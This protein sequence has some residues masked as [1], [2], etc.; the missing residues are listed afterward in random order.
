MAATGTPDR[1]AIGRDRTSGETATGRGTG[2]LTYPGL[3]ARARAGAAVLRDRQARALV[4]IGVNGSAFAEALF[5]SA[6][7]GIP[8]VPLNYRLSREQLAFLL[9]RQERALV[10]SDLDPPAEGPV[11]TTRQ[12]SE[13]FD[14]TASEGPQ[15]LEHSVGRA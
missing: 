6:W 1:V 3:L 13:L 4:Y 2:Q 8:L 9:G 12:W 15:W 10:V 11:L 7:A 5:A 14:V